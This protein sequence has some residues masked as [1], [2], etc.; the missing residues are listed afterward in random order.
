MNWFTRKKE[1]LKS[2]LSE[3]EEEKEAQKK[4]LLDIYASHK[5][6]LDACE[7]FLNEHYPI[8]DFDNIPEA[9]VAFIFTIYKTA[10]E[11]ADSL[12]ALNHLNKHYSGYSYGSEFEGYKK[13]NALNTYR[14]YKNR[15]EGIKASHTYRFLEGI[16]EHKELE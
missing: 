12:N 14:W 9:V 15:V 4:E 1:E 2:N 10:E 7:L 6:K 11:T 13:I 8:D 5:K 16:N 3:N